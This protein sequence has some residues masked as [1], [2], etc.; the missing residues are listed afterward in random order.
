MMDFEDYLGSTKR[1][2]R[3]LARRA[4]KGDKNAMNDLRTITTRLKVMVNKRLR[5]LQHSGLDYG[6][7]YNDLLYYTQTQYKKNRLL[8][9]N[10]LDNDVD[11]ML[12]QNEV[13]LKFL[14]SGWSTVEKAKSAEQYRIDRLKEITALPENFTRRRNVKFL[15]WLGNE[16]SSA[17][18][19]RYGRSEVFVDMAYDVYKE[20]GEAGLRTLSV[21]VTEYLA[22]KKT[23]D[24]A[25]KG[26]GI[27]IEDYLSKKYKK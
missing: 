21:L 25:M 24:E 19:D 1:Q 16:E 20:K 11:T 26:V 22:D 6:R 9:A 17:A 15:R 27:K 13:A 3:A 12:L 14:K 4:S 7:N 23:F 8:S 10:E 2:R 18:M 5:A